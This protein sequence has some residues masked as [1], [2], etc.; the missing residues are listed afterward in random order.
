MTIPTAALKSDDV[1][2]QDLFWLLDDIVA[3]ARNPNVV[4]V[5]VLCS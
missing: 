4:T 3:T 5:F 1:L 2:G